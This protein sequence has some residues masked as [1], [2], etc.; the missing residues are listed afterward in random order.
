MPGPDGVPHPEGGAY[1]GVEAFDLVVREPVT[2]IG[3]E[4]DAT[5]L[6]EVLTTT[7]RRTGLPLVVTENGA[8][9][10]D[11]RVEDGVVVDEDRIDYLRDHTAAVVEARREGADV[12]GYFVWTL[13]DNFEWAEGYTKTF[14]V[15]H[16]DPDDQ[17][18][19]PK[20]S[21]RWLA[22]EATDL[23]EAARS[24]SP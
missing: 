8:A 5:G 2:D 1:P 4:I 7:H 22:A 13:L 17:T 24:V 10:A 20:A 14:G 15:V 12:R 6:T 23:R 9:M 16:V 3:W 21:Y 19:T 18:R 11:D